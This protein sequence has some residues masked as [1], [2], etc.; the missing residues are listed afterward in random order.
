MKII[1][2]IY[3]CLVPS[4]FFQLAMVCLLVLLSVIFGQSI[5]RL[6]SLGLWFFPSQQRHSIYD[7]LIRGNKI[8]INRIGTWI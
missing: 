7:N 4:G 2:S 8:I 3:Q 1:Q 5:T 6:I